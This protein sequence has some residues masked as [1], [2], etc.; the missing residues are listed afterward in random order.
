MKLSINEIKNRSDEKRGVKSKSYK[1]PLT[2][3][4]EIEQLSKQFN[5][6]QN[7]LIIQAVLCYLFQLQRRCQ[8][9][10]SCHHAIH[11]QTITFTVGITIGLRY[12]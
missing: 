8:Q 5:I 4:V 12:A 9:R 11:I 10:Q 3:I 6:A 2:V 1:L 7:Q